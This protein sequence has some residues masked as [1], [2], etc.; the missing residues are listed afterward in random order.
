[1]VKTSAE[2]S[3]ATVSKLHKLE[4]TQKV[5][6]KERK[7]PPEE[8][9]KIAVSAKKGV[10]KAAPDKTKIRVN[11]KLIEADRIHLPKHFIS[12]PLIREEQRKLN[13]I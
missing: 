12:K 11:T 5:M 7:Q 9:K 6:G 1:M 4:P 2:V 10:V 3:P 13:E 8:E